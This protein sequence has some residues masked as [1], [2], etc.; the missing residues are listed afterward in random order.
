MRY[1]ARQIIIMS[2]IIL[3]VVAIVALAYHLLVFR[4]TKTIPVNNTFPSFVKYV[5]VYTSQPIKSVGSVT[6]NSVPATGN[7]EING[8]WLR[9]NNPDVFTKDT[10]MTLVIQDVTSE[11]GSSID[12]TYTFTPRYM[13]FSDV[14]SEVRERSIDKSSSGQT[15]DPFF[16]NYFPIVNRDDSYEIE[17]IYD[18]THLTERVLYVTFY[19]EVYDYD[20]NQQNTLPN[21]QAEAKRLKVL[22]QIRSMGGKPE[23]YHIQYANQYLEHKYNPDGHGEEE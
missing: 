2:G 11:R 12:I 13:D 3:M 18:K 15:D 21:D 9:Y 5:E 8:N 10:E 16:N 17:L 14:P 23:N 6:L 22:E 7:V 19:E 20:T 1:S 4:V